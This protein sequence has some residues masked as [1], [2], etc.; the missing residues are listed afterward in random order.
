MTMTP[1]D[2]TAAEEEITLREGGCLFYLSLA[3]NT[4][5]HRVTSEME[6]GSERVYTAKYL[7]R[8]LRQIRRERAAMGL[9][10]LPRKPVTLFGVDSDV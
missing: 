6:D 8:C 7:R 9:P 10:P 1:D 2:R 5:N 4:E 3:E